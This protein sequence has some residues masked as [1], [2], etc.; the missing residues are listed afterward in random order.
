MD[1]QNTASTKSRGRGFR[2]IQIFVK[3]DDPKTVA[4]QVSPEDTKSRRS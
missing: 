1:G 2:R 3:A 4:M